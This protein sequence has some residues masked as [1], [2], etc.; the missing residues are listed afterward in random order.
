[1]NTQ[2]FI[3][4]SN[5]IWNNL[6]DYSITNYINST[7]KI[8]I[9]CKTHGLFEQLP[10]NHYKY[11]G[12]VKCRLP[13]KNN[14]LLKIEAS[15][16]F[17]SKANKIHGNDIYN[18]DKSVYITSNI[19]LIVICNL[20]GEFEISPNNHLSGKG[21]FKCGYITRGYSSRKLLLHY[22][23]TFKNLFGDKYGD[24]F[25]IDWNGG[26]KNIKLICKKHGEFNILPY[27]HAQVK[28]CPKCKKNRTNK[29]WMCFFMF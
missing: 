6:Y 21:C 18:Y 17:I 20:H 7:T 24:Y 27:L 11:N 26:S 23:Q 2:I 1:M 5:K 8:K 10:P 4:K 25:N 19:K 14:E 13:S 9:I 29:I 15:N 12:C 16:N 3:E 28:E 22:I